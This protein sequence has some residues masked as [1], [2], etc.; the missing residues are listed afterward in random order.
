MPASVERPAK[1]CGSFKGFLREAT[2]G[3]GEAEGRREDKRRVNGVELK[4]TR[5]EL[6]EQDKEEESRRKGKTDQQKDRE[7]GKEEP[8]PAAAKDYDGNQQR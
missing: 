5:G 3:D 2:K 4:L 8:G 1:A 6:P 7:K